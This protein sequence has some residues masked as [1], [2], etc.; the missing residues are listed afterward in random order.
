MLEQIKQRCG[1][2]YSVAA[3]DI[4]IEDYINECIEDLISSGV[5]ENIAKSDNPAVITAITLY[6]KALIGDD[7][8]DTQKYLEL[9]RQ[10]VFRL[11][12]EGE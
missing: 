10:K 12:L 11:T 2:A 4:E 3:Y 8:T 7:R 9:Y 6:V 5:P 1:I